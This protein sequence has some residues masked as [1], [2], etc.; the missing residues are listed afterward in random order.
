MVGEPR[1]ARRDER[2]STLVLVPA[3]ALV[4]VA[5][6]GIAVDL[7]SVHI[8]QRRAGAVLAAAADDAAAMIDTRRIQLDGRAIVD[9]SAARR[10]VTAHLRATPPPGTLERLTVEVLPDR[11]RIEATVRLR[12]IVL[13]GLPGR[14]GED[15]YTVRAEAVVAP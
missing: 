3:L 2:G 13:R 8:Q 1:R 12:R 15:A 5:L 7:T 4:A 6:S 11:V 10:V 14:S 9:E